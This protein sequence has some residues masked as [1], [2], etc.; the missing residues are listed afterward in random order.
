[1]LSPIYV[2]TNVP[3]CAT[4]DIALATPAAALFVGIT[5]YPEPAGVF[6]TPAHFIGANLFAGI[7]SNAASR[8]QSLPYESETLTD[9][10]KRDEL[11]KN[12]A[13]PMDVVSALGFGGGG[14]GYDVPR[15]EIETALAAQIA[16]AERIYEK[17][18]HVL[19][20]VYVAAHGFLSD[21]EPYFLPSDA[22][23]D[24]PETWISYRSVVAAAAAF[25]S[26]NAPGSNARTA[27]VIFDTCQVRHG[28]EN[29]PKAEIPLPPGLVL[30][31]SAAPGEYAWHWTAS[32]SYQYDKQMV[33]ETRIG[34]G[35]PPKERRGHIHGESAG[36]MS[37]L[38]IANQCFLA[39]A[40]KAH[41][42]QRGAD[43]LLSVREWFTGVKT[44]ADSYFVKIP[45]MQSLGRT[46]TISIRVADA[47]FDPP[48]F[49]LRQSKPPSER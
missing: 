49:V 37:V 13:N 36:T 24:K 40:I 44:K 19:L 8:A 42:Q 29:V 9:L 18:G 20:I 34:I 15:K 17:Q 1:V 14:K 26:R 32:N 22:I 5:N 33:K 10:A 2:Q 6:S 4:R 43:A 11:P 47:Q 48:L 12:Y 28:G 38:P 25:L 3:D 46:Q 35:L 45:E 7:F 41:K 27:L 16:K 23:A 21:G 30:V 39:D 31:Q